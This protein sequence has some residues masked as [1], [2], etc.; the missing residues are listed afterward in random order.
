MMF[1]VLWH[2]SA[3]SFRRQSLL[4]PTIVSYAVVQPSRW[5]MGLRMMWWCSGKWGVGGGVRRGDG[6][7]RREERRDGP[8]DG[9]KWEVGENRRGEQKSERRSES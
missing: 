3:T 4:F 7:G 5:L 8:R 1:E 9:K 2:T 6:R